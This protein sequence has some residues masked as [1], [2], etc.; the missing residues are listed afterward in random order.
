MTARLHTVAETQAF[1]RDA[2][3]A[4]VTGEQRTAM[5][6]AIA[7]DPK[8]GDEIRGSGGVRKRRFAGR[9]KGKSGGYR[10]LTAYFGERAPVYAVALLSKGERADFSPKEIAELKALTAEIGKHWRERR[11]R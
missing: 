6:L 5:V 8:G 4:G 3:N 1:I 11:A 2:E 9:G 7:A 10:V